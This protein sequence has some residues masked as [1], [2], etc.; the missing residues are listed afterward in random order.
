MVNMADEGRVIVLVGGPEDGRIIKG[1]E[2]LMVVLRVK[3]TS[4]EE[5]MQLTEPKIGS[6]F[7]ITSSRLIEAIDKLGED[8]LIYFQRFGV[9][10]EQMESNRYC[11]TEVIDGLYVYRFAPSQ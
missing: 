9:A 6:C 8:A 1:R 7:K 10:N 3:P 2:A 11:L 5:V 4:E